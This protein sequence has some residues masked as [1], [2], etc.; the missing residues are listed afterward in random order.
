MMDGPCILIVGSL[1]NGFRFYGPYDDVGT[2]DEAG[3][4]HFK[5]EG[6]E[7]AQVGKRLEAPLG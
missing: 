5:H 7:I 2:A 1:E 3:A 6:Y 4:Y